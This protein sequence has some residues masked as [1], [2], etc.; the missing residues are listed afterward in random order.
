M[1]IHAAKLTALMLILMGCS[2]IP[3]RNSGLDQARSSLGTALRQPHLGSLASDELARAGMTLRMAERSWATGS[4]SATVDHLAY[5]TMQRIAIARELTLRYQAE[6]AIQAY[7]RAHD[8]LLG[9]D[10]SPLPI[11]PLTHDQ[12]PIALQ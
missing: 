10:M 1:P 5:M 9:Y 7:S 12:R 11:A 3:E 4:N 8:Q 2:G 6:Q